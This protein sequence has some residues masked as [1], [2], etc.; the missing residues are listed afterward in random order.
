MQP[1]TILSTSSTPNKK[2]QLNTSLQQSLCQKK[3]KMMLVRL[4]RKL[5]FQIMFQNKYLSKLSTHTNTTHTHT[6]SP[7]LRQLRKQRLRRLQ[8][9]ERKEVKDVE[10]EAESEVSTAAER[11]A[12]KVAEG[13]MV[14][15]EVVVT[16]AEVVADI[17]LDRK[18]KMVSSP[19]LETNQSQGEEVAE[20]AS[21]VIVVVSAVA[22]APIVVESGEDKEV[23]TAVTAATDVAAIAPRRRELL[24]Q[25]NN[26]SNHNNE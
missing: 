12:E 24:S 8:V 6:P 17:G 14:V 2:K 15:E 1:S 19:R 5:R 7:M 22:N 9:R 11:E 21:V 10:A 18:M 4:K 25:L 13:A 26:N 3:A 23:S 16:T 20:V